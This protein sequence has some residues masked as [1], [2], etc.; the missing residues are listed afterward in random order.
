MPSLTSIMVASLLALSAIAAP[1]G[2]SL[3]KERDALAVA[4]RANPTQNRGCY[5][6]PATGAVYCTNKRDADAISGPVPELSRA[7]RD[8]VENLAE[9]DAFAANP[10][11]HTCSSSDIMCPPHK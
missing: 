6:I 3:L 5:T 10:T 1:V 8:A 4:P 9:R 7:E 11:P 2:P